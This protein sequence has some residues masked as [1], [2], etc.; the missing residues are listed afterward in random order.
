M[1]Y[2][3]PVPTKTRTGGHHAMTKK[4]LYFPPK[5]RKIQLNMENFARIFYLS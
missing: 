1:Y 2:Y 3:M 4:E 5:L